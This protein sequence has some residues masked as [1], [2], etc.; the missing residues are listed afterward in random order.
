MVGS[1]ETVR[2]QR[3]DLEELVES[4]DD[5]EEQHEGLEHD[6]PDRALAGVQVSEWDHEH[7]C[8]GLALEARPLLPRELNGG[9][10]VERRVVEGEVDEDRA[11]LPVDPQ[12]LEELARAART[13]G[14]SALAA[15]LSVESRCRRMTAKARRTIGLAL[16][17]VGGRGCLGQGENCSWERRV[18]SGWYCGHVSSSAIRN[19]AGERGPVAKAKLPACLRRGLQN[20]RESV[21]V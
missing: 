19:A 18:F 15:E 11:A 12:R 5:D 4:E 10:A 9:E 16:R 3:T 17:K 13:V 6:E 8:R 14:G 20:V 21:S 7:L 1:Q 2:E